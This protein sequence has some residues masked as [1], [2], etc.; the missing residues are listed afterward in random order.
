MLIT[1]FQFRIFNMSASV[2]NNYNKILDEYVLHLQNKDSYFSILKNGVLNP[3]N[4][5]LK[6]LFSIMNINY[7]LPSLITIENSILS[8]KYGYIFNYDYPNF[9][10]IA[11]LVLDVKPRIWKHFL[12]VLKTY[13]HH[14]LLSEI[15]ED[16]NIQ[17]KIQR[18]IDDINNPIHIYNTY[19]EFLC[20][21]LDGRL[22]GWGAGEDLKN[23][24]FKDKKNTYPVIILRNLLQ[25]NP[26]ITQYQPD[27]VIDT[28]KKYIDFSLENLDHINKEILYK[29]F[30]FICEN[31]SKKEQ[32][33]MLKYYGEFPSDMEFKKI[34]GSIVDALNLEHLIDDVYFCDNYCTF[35]IKDNQ[36]DFS[37]ETDIGWKNIKDKSILIYGITYAENKINKK[38]DSDF[39][40]EKIN[41]Y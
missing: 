31:L 23:S 14:I 34:L 13:N 9:K 25:D 4:K 8:A 18:K 1:Y 28:I 20:P 39:F 36:I 11:H 37:Y 21:A 3:E 24:L 22:I 38:F 6:Q 5:K 12:L 40:V 7:N 33:S 19:I 32:G 30:D 35:K 29:I 27:Q 16:S 2:L 41:F 15:L 26:Q 17:K 10:N